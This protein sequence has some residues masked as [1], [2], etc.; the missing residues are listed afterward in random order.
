M[1]IVQKQ[2]AELREYENNP[3]INDGA[4]A[5][6]AE[7]IE[8]FGFKVPIVIDGGGVILAVIDTPFFYLLTRKR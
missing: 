2:V 5:A 7:S 8:R 1:D 3:R 6:V 4:V